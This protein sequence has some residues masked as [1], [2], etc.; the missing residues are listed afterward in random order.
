VA[1]RACRTRE[2]KRE[3]LETRRRDFCQKFGLKYDEDQHLIKIRAKKK[4]QDIADYLGLKPTDYDLATGK[5]FSTEK[6]GYT[7]KSAFV[8]TKQ[9]G[10]IAVVRI[11]STNDD[12]DDCYAVS[13]LKEW[14]WEKVYD[15]HRTPEQIAEQIAQEERYKKLR[16]ENEAK[17]VEW[18]K[19]NN[20]RLSAERIALDSQVKHTAIPHAVIDELVTLAVKHT[21]EQR[22][23]SPDRRPTFAPP[24]S[25][26]KELVDALE[27]SR[28]LYPNREFEQGYGRLWAVWESPKKAHGKCKG[29]ELRAGKAHDGELITKIRPGYGG[30]WWTGPNW[31]TPSSDLRQGMTEGQITT[32]Q[33]KF[34]ERK[35]RFIL[36]SG[37]RELGI[38]EILKFAG[39]PEEVML[40]GAR[41]AGI[42]CEC[43]RELTDPTSMALGI[44]PECIKGAI[45]IN[46]KLNGWTKEQTEA[47]Y[48]AQQDKQTVLV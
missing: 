25:F 20:E 34:N 36:D 17:R 42:C 24:I 15:H 18:E 44:G 26:S 11:T 32:E 6:D 16:E 46:R 47:Y 38:A 9:G 21:E 8:S 35:E 45:W 10:W 33:K 28:S 23:N 13:K 48:L 19:K 39:A 29:F 43:G 27:R 14:I 2:R 12:N 22:E 3:A 40:A 1:R 5:V 41:L 31:S 37:L 30:G 4:C 7:F